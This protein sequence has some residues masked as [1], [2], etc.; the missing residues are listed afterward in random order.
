VQ[1]FD[2][3]AVV[4]VKHAN[5]CGVALAGDIT[6]AY[7]AANA[8]DPTS[9]FGGIVAANRPV[10]AALA[11]ALAP[12]FTEVVVAPAFD[13]NAL[14]VLAA[15]KNLR[16]LSAPPPF[17]AGLDLRSI[18]GGLLVQQAD[19]VSLDRSAWRV[20][21]KVGPDDELWSELA[22]AWQVCAAVSSNAIV[23]TRDRQ[24]V[25][26]GAGQQNRLDSAGIAVTKAAGRA[27]G[28]CCASDAFFPFRD[29]LDAVA[30]AG[31]R[32]VIQPGGSVRDE[33]VIAAADEHGLVMVFTGERHFRH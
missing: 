32:A 8:C 11:E 22:F 20:V 17:G 31:V 26:I 30:A 28:G 4:I 1:R 12:V 19:T 27:D 13:D 21:T 25:G 16:V 23:L 33:E 29:G 9:A 10:P 15:K 5:P 2:E 24:A 6:D 18:D 14:Q 7:V 3:P